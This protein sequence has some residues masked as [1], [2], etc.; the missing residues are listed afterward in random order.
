MRS[1]P[2]VTL[3]R[4]WSGV[5]W[6]GPHSPWPRP[7]APPAPA[8]LAPRG[9]PASK[10][11]WPRPTS[12]ARPSSATAL[13]L[14]DADRLPDARPDAGSPSFRRDLSAR[15]GLSDPGGVTGSSHD[16]AS[17]VAFGQYDGLRPR[18]NG[19]SGLNHTPHAAA[20]YAS[21]PSLPPAHATLASRR[22]ATPYLGWTSTSRS[23][24]PPGA[25]RIAPIRNGRWGVDLPDGKIRLTPIPPYGYAPSE[26][27]TATA[28]YI[29]AAGWRRCRRASRVRRS[30][31]GA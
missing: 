18:D 22:L 11:L 7:F 3:S 28:A 30:C 16:G 31:R 5:C 13:H 9:S 20:V 6:S 15:D 19:I 10:L 24:Q 27:T 29:R 23:R 8:K 12:R 14:P 2:W 17:H 25:F 1:S 21:W 26:S 4:L